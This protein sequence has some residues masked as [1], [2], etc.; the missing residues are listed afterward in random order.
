MGGVIGRGAGAD[1]SPGLGRQGC[2]SRFAASGLRAHRLLH[3]CGMAHLAILLPV[4]TLVGFPALAAFG[5]C[6]SDVRR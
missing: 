2:M 5:L 4:V 6:M 3:S 1:D